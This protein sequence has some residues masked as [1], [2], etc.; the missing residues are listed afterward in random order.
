MP[1]IQ[2]PCVDCQGEIK[3]QI[4]QAVINRALRW[5]TSYICPFSGAAV[6]ADDI[7]FTDPVRY[8]QSIEHLY[9]LD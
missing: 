1:Q 4:G 7:A 6:E 3:L 9:F 8:N 2:G 5:H